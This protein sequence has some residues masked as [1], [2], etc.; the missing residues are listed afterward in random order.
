MVF[1]NDQGSENHFFPCIIHEPAMV[2]RL[3]ALSHADTPHH[4][5]M[6]VTATDSHCKKVEQWIDFQEFKLMR[7]GFSKQPFESSS[8]LDKIGDSAI[9]RADGFTVMK[10]DLHMRF[11][12][13]V[14]LVSVLL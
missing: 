4:S 6:P 1:P 13:V 9:F 10:H 8:I 5:L 11:N 2:P 3:T 12:A 7:F 14:P